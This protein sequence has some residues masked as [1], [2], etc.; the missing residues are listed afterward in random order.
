[1]K[2]A[3]SVFPAGLA[4]YL[5]EMSLKLQQYRSDLKM[6]ALGVYFCVNIPLWVKCVLISPTGRSKPDTR[7]NT[8]AFVP[9]R[10]TPLAIPGMQ[11]RDGLH[12]WMWPAGAA[13]CR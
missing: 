12:C 6:H 10:T 9:S 13:L 11:G 2:P 1:M 3:G 8:C 7:R 4:L 5:C